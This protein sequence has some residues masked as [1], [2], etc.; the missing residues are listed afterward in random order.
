M[1]SIAT[2][3]LAIVLALQLIYCDICA[4][5]IV[6]NKNSP[7]LPEMPVTI[8]ENEKLS[9]YGSGASYTHKNDNAIVNINIGMGKYDRGQVMTGADFAV[10]TGMHS[11]MGMKLLSSRDK[12]EAVLGSAHTLPSSNLHFRT[13]ISYM[14][15]SQQFN[16]FRSSERANLSQL[17]YYGGFDWIN[18]SKSDIGLQSIGLAVWGAKGKN[19]SSFD[20]QTYYDLNQNYLIK[21]QDKRLLAEGQLSGGSINTQYSAH[22]DVVM[23]SMIGAEYLK[24]PYSDGTGYSKY[25]PMFAQNIEYHLN[26]NNGVTLGYKYGM[27]EQVLRAD[28]KH[29][30]YNVSAYK[31]AGRNSMSGSYGVNL[32]VNIL[33]LLEKSK[34]K[35][36]QSTLASRMKPKIIDNNRQLLQESITRPIQLPS[37]FLVK[38]DPTAVTY[39]RFDLAAFANVPGVQVLGVDASGNLS[40]TLPINYNMLLNHAGIPNDALSIQGNVLTIQTSKI[41]KNAANNNYT[42]TISDPGTGMI[43]DLIFSVA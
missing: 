16:F 33:A 22:D 42:I 26:H 9:I 6:K 37:N 27:S 5:A 35:K 3:K 18:R 23:T 1:K 41:S 43:I 2:E 31:T 15:G 14:Q 8:N 40:V 34:N 12:L 38:V 19:K 24:F 32:S 21:T 4:E 20:T 30:E 13:A 29:K 11:A 36:H 39:E 10:M 7:L 17:G 25:S 28:F